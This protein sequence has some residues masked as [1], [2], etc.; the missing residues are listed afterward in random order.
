MTNNNEALDLIDAAL[1]KQSLDPLT[2]KTLQSARQDIARELASDK[3][4]EYGVIGP[5]GRMVNNGDYRTQQTHRRR[6]PGPWEEIEAV[7]VNEPPRPQDTS[8][9][10]REAIA[11]T[12]WEAEVAHNPE[13]ATE[14]IDSWDAL[15]ADEPEW[16]SGYQY[17]AERVMASSEGRNRG[18]GPI[19]DK[20]VTAAWDV[21]ALD[22]MGHY[23]RRNMR[24]ALEAAEAAR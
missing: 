7:H 11:R 23:S 5:T 15:I 4:W 12:L 6:A 2:R 3:I 8:D 16:A 13:G 21:I 17:Q 20:M 9:D 1:A 18:R 24:A 19:T 22:N 14:G 10:E